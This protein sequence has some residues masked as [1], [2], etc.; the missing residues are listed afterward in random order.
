MTPEVK[1]ILEVSGMALFCAHLVSCIYFFLSKANDFG[2][3]TWVAKRGVTDRSSSYQY[4]VAFYWSVII[5]TVGFG[6]VST[7][8]VSEMLL[9]VFWMIISVMFY[10]FILGNL[11]S[12]N[13]SQNS[14]KTRLKICLSYL[15]II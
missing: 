4:L 15:S 14:K 9:S 12:L 1:R 5:T 2:P 7:D 3:D 10:A 8:S 11:F 13:I 6:D